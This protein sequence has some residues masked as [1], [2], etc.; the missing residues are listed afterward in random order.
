MTVKKKTKL[1][2]YDRT[3]VD[4]GV[5]FNIVLRGQEK[6]E[7]DAPGNFKVKQPYK[8]RLFSLRIYPEGF[9]ALRSSHTEIERVKPTQSFDKDAWRDFVH[10][11]KEH[12]GAFGEALIGA[13]E[14]VTVEEP[15]KMPVYTLRN[16]D[17]ARRQKKAA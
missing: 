17:E 15:E 6:P 13:I 10:V 9:E 16:R 11:L 4:G 2:L 8:Q 7:I 12:G 14:S 5:E 1:T 3:E